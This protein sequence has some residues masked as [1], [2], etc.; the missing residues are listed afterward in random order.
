MVTVD[1]V[2]AL[3]FFDESQKIDCSS[4][5]SINEGSTVSFYA[6]LSKYLKDVTCQ[7]NIQGATPSTFTGDTARVV[8]NSPG[9]KTVSVAITATKGDL[10]CSKVLSLELMVLSS[11]KGFFV[12]QNVTGGANDGT[13]WANAYRTI[14]DALAHAGVDNHIWVAKG[15]YNP[16]H[17]AAF[18]V[19]Y[20]SIKIFGGFAGWETQ[21]SERD[22]AKNQTILKGNGKSVIINT[23]ANG[24]LQVT[25]PI[26]ITI[27]GVN[28]VSN[29]EIDLRKVWA[30]GN[31]LYIKT[32]QESEVRIYTI[33]G[34]LYVQRRIKGPET[35][36]V[37]APGVYTVVVD[38]DTYK[39]L[40]K[41]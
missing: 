26:N 19:H 18:L 1:T 14:Q 29:N 11:H 32:D 10:T 28:P 3:I 30:Y 27:N 8:F 35:V 33:S 31:K 16:D 36:I 15:T 13:S 20:D 5:G 41:D 6:P 21:L 25:E 38:N 2:Y 17:D 23:D 7:W 24:I 22:F 34:N 9:K 37:L 4:T 40:I 39:I 12:D